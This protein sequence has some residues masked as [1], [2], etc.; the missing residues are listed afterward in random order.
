MAS[1]CRP[2]VHRCAASDGRASPTRLR[3]LEAIDV[4]TLVVGGPEDTV[5]TPDV[6]RRMA[7][8]IPKS[9]VEISSDAVIS[10]RSSGRA[11][12]HVGNARAHAGHK[13]RR[14]P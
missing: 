3:C 10:V 1:P 6:L 4:P 8:S 13:H 12:N 5:T 7:A 2:R 9:R 11:F 14:R